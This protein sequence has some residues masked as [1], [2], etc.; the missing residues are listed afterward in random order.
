[1]VS[2]LASQVWSSN[3]MPRKALGVLRQAQD[4]RIE[5]EEIPFMLSSSKHSLAFFSILPICKITRDT[6]KGEYYGF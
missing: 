4:E 1:M 5:I 3:K 6:E 2:A